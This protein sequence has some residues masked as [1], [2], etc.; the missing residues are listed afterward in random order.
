M[1]L[2]PIDTDDDA[3]L[4]PPGVLGSELASWFLR[5]HGRPA[6][7]MELSALLVARTKSRRRRILCWRDQGLDEKQIVD[8]LVGE[9]V[10]SPEAI[11]GAAITAA[12]LD[13]LRVLFREIVE[14][15]LIKYSSTGEGEFLRSPW[16][17]LHAARDY[18]DSKLKN[19]PVDPEA[20]YLLSWDILAALNA[21]DAEGL[22]G[23]RY[24]LHERARGPVVAQEAVIKELTV[25][26]R[27]VR[28]THP[29]IQAQLAVPEPGP[30]RGLAP[31][32]RERGGEDEWKRVLDSAA[33]AAGLG[34]LP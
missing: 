2:A 8:K 5:R 13:A 24:L 26:G 32:R 22:E 14:V 23:W 28:E 18:A 27:R 11:A 17:I 4:P 12:A 21:T 15:A 31:L 29:E 7:H 3:D 25:A 19:R 10:S 30:P 1:R 33:E 9:F 20:K 16:P 6:T 34:R